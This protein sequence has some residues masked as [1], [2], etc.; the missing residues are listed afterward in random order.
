MREYYKCIKDPREYRQYYTV[1]KLYKRVQ[2]SKNRSTIIITLIDDNNKY[3]EMGVNSWLGDC[4]ILYK[5]FN[6]SWLKLKSLF[7]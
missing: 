1:G 4:F 7:L 6:Y 2:N 5:S 3:V